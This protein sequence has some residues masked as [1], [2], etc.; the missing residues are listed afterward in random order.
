MLV[1]QLLPESFVVAAGLFFGG[2]DDRLSRR[3]APRR[4]RE[5]GPVGRPG[6]IAERT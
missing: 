2:K 5:R 3:S 4:R 6:G 1:R